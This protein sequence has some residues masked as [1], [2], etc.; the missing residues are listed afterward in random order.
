MGQANM[1]K[2]ACIGIVS[3]NPLGKRLINGNT[4]CRT[5]NKPRYMFF[6]ELQLQMVL[7]NTLPKTILYIHELL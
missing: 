5:K 3:Y 4:R 6:F 1:S 2:D 7:V